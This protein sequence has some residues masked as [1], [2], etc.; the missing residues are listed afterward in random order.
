M[1][2]TVWRTFADEQIDKA[3]REGQFDNLEGKGRPLCLE[4]DSMVPEELRMAYKILKNSGHVPPEVADRKEI[5]TIVEM[6][7]SCPDE[8]TRYRQIKKLNMLVTRW[9]MRRPRPVML[10]KQQLYYEKVVERVEVA[11]RSGGKKGGT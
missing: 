8:Q 4:D 10:E 1:P 3:M 11:E 2:F 9:N 5:Q 6:L 7:E